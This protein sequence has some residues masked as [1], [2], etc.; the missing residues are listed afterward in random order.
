[1]RSTNV[2]SAVHETSCIIFKKMF[3]TESVIRHLNDGG[4]KSLNMTF[5]WL[6]GRSAIGAC[7]Y[8]L[9]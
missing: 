3:P 8:F 9:N 6:A 1:M 2:R 5:T 4:N 7:E